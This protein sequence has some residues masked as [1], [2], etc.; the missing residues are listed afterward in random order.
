MLVIVKE[1]TVQAAFGRM[2]RSAPK[3]FA[4]LPLELPEKYLQ[5]VKNWR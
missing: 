2:S 1:Y 5:R 4:Y 3:A